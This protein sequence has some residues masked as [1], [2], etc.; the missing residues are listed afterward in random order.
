MGVKTTIPILFCAAAAILGTSQQYK[1]GD[2]KLVVTAS[3]V[4]RKI[5]HKS[6]RLTI[7]DSAY[8]NYEVIWLTIKVKVTNHSKDSI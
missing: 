2:K 8:Y 5:S 4:E 7:H 1:P 6:M 3:I